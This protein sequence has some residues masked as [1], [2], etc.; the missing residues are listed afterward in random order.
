VFSWF[1]S[2]RRRRQLLAEDPPRQW[3]ELVAKSVAV[4]SLLPAKEQKRLLAVSRILAEERHWVGCQGLVVSDEMKAAVAGQAALLLLGVEGYYFDKIREIYLLPGDYVARKV[5]GPVIAGDT[6]PLLVEPLHFEEEDVPLLGQASST[7]RIVLS[8]P[9]ALA[10][11]RDPDDG[12]ST[13]LHEFAHH[14][15]MLDGHAGGHPPQ[16]TRQAA[17]EWDR[18]IDAEYARLLRMLASRE[19][20]LLDPYAAESKAE[21]FSVATEVFFERPLELSRQHS[22]LYG[23][24]R[25]FY[26][27][28]PRDWFP[29]DATKTRHEHRRPRVKSDARP[30]RTRPLPP[31][32]RADDYFTRGWDAFLDDRWEE[33]EADFSEVLRRK[34]QDVEALIHRA[35]CRL[36]SGQLA[37]AVQ[38]AQV[39]CQIATDDAQ[40]LRIRGM[41]RAAM[42]DS[43]Q[44][45][46]DLT[47][48]LAGG[49]D[50]EE[51]HFYRG[52]A[53]ADLG[54]WKQAIEDFT[55][56]IRA[57]PA[58]APA[59]LERSDCHAALGDR[60]S[61]ERDRQRAL[62]L[63]PALANE[64]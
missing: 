2:G 43:D 16:P 47:Q 63:D 39:A 57:D 23:I 11:G 49:A 3:R 38:D 42:G 59:W 41:C 51:A 25:S 30:S 6:V 54:R 21:F 12:R 19:A 7:H 18:V 29:E 34:P 8:W 15:D 31:L 4:L 28:N 45:V 17:D 64:P 53:L 26:Q 60:A 5:A 46:A 36:N 13:V 56:V 1:F 32:E 24:L 9:E 27:V 61:A 33:A 20:T 48:A 22:A 37:A 44:A 55:A 35:E 14:L 52:T 62:E 40:A 10:G 50:D 58:D